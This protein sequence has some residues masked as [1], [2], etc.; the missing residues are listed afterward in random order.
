MKLLCNYLTSGE[1]LRRLPHLLSTLPPP[2]TIMD[3]NYSAGLHET[4]KVKNY[5]LIT[6]LE[7]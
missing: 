2:R 3:F 7:L 5:S 6:L 1:L 4:L